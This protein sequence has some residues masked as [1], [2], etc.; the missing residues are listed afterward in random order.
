MN[1]N[2][3]E[4]NFNGLPKPTDW[5]KVIVPLQQA[6]EKEFRGATL[7]ELGANLKIEMSV[8]AQR[9]PSVPPGAL[10]AGP[11]DREVFME[12]KV[13]GSWTWGTNPPL[14]NAQGDISTFWWDMTDWRKNDRAALPFTPA[15]PMIIKD[16]TL[17]TSQDAVYQ[18]LDPIMISG[19]ELQFTL[20]PGYVNAEGVFVNS[21]N[22]L[23]AVIEG[24]IS[25][26]QY[27]TRGF[28]VS[29][30][31]SASLLASTRVN[32]FSGNS[33]LGKS[34]SS[35]S[36]DFAFNTLLNN[37][38]VIIN[39]EASEGVGLNLETSPF[40]KSLKVFMGTELK[41]STIK[42]DKIL[43]NIETEQI[44]KLEA[45]AQVASIAALSGNGSPLTVQ[46]TE[47]SQYIDYS[48]G[49]I[50]R[51][52]VGKWGNGIPLGGQ[53]RKIE[54]PEGFPWQPFN[55]YKLSSNGVY[56]PEVTDISLKVID[57]ISAMIPY[58]VDPIKGSDS[59]DGKSRTKAFNTCS[60]AITA[61]ASLVYLMDGIYDRDHALA[62]LLVTKNMAFIA[63]SGANPI[64]TSWDNASKYAWTASENVHFT[65]RSALHNVIDANK[66]LSDKEGF[67]MYSKVDTLA[68]CKAIA[69]TFY[70]DIDIVYV[71]NNGVAPSA[72]IK[73]CVRQ[74]ICE[75]VLA[76]NVDF[77][78]IEGITSYVQSDKGGI[79]LLNSAST[80]YNG[81]YYVKNCRSYGN[82]M[83]NAFS[84]DNV[85]EVWNQNC[86]GAKCLRDAHNYHVSMLVNGYEKMK[87]VEM[88]SSAFNTGWEA[89]TEASSNG[90]TAHEGMTIIRFLGQFD[91][92]R[93]S[94]IA[95]VN[96]GI[97]SLNFNTEAS[98]SYLANKA[99]FH[100]QDGKMWL[101]GAYA[102]NGTQAARADGVIEPST[103]FYDDA[104]LL[105][106]EKFGNVIPLQ[107]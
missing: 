40:N 101:Y 31:Q 13:P 9:I 18:Y 66:Y 51:K 8:N 5:K 21:N 72:N 52:Q 61:G 37:D 50:Y 83:G 63:D 67:F 78:Y 34:A 59:N 14:T 19:N 90:S 12:I 39:V 41:M 56:V 81:K 69:F 17:A 95:D 54:Y 73:L 87:A 77:V 58:Y 99:C 42:G 45:S 32:Y 6:N 84:Y 86:F 36:G 60:K 64:M 10:V 91:L 93:G 55:I 76:A 75:F 94:T 43:G 102:H 7:P 85:K 11:A 79:A 23:C 100:I 16:G 105:E 104:S 98:G 107:T 65:S 88:N 33:Y 28:G 71:N 38:K 70:V 47:G 106:G 89:T 103:I 80:Q 62:R 29:S 57:Q 74:Y 24:V 2:I 22:W 20:L 49:L 97:R 15:A 35:G 48:A 82:R 4:P 53:K 92:S 3:L 1:D 25:Q 46:G 30:G 44:K 27:T 26:Q 96:Q 68:A